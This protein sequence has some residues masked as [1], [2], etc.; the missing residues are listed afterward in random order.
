MQEAC[1]SASAHRSAPKAPGK[2]LKSGDGKQ[3]VRRLVETSFGSALG[4]GAAGPLLSDD[5]SGFR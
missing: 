3:L 4:R 5:G 2:S 1:L